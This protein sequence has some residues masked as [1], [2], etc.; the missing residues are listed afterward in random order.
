MPTCHVIATE[1]KELYFTAALILD[2]LTERSID[3]K[4]APVPP[5]NILINDKRIVTAKFKNHGSHISAKSIPAERPKTEDA[6]SELVELL[7]SI[8]KS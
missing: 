1:L 4:V 8:V 2:T 6:E 5:S 7:T 3:C